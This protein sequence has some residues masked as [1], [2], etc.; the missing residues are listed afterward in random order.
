MYRHSKYESVNI[1]EEIDHL[2]EEIKELQEVN[3]EKN[4]LL[5]E[6]EELKTQNFILKQKIQQTIANV[7][8]K[9]DDLAKLSEKVELLES[10][11]EDESGELR[12]EN[13]DL[14]CVNKILKNRLSHMKDSN[15]Y[16]YKYKCCQCN[17]GSRY[18]EKF[19]EHM[20]AD[21][22]EIKKEFYVESGCIAVESCCICKKVFYSTEDLE[23]HTQMEIHCSM[24]DICTT[25]GRSELDYCAASYQFESHF[26]KSVENSKIAG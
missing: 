25:V 11:S 9:N 24:C 7:S 3:K 21:H 22:E 17:F 6:C 8:Q 12:K 1:E 23:K 10:K 26:D 20:T 5:K 13:K 15:V 4:N 2:N 14:N 16:I 18:M 19:K